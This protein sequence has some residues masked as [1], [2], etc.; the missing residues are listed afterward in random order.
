M[1]PWEKIKNCE[2]CRKIMTVGR[3]TYSVRWN[4]FNLDSISTCNVQ[5]FRERL[6]KS[7][8][9]AYVIMLKSIIMV[10]CQFQSRKTW[11]QCYRKR[12]LQIYA[13]TLLLTFW[14]MSE[15]QNS[16]KWSRPWISNKGLGFTETRKHDSN[17]FNLTYERNVP[18]IVA[19]V[20]SHHFF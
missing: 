19:H 14:D 3:S 17:D 4:L 11:R 13:H 15:F 10:N 6:S 7:S 2:T 18:K 5:L 20:Q 8:I 1:R 16:V 12:C 9:K